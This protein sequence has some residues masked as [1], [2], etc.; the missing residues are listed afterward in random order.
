MTMGRGRGWKD[1]NKI[2]TKEKEQKVVLDGKKKRKK[3]T[4]V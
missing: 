3:K 1:T 2:V 4:W